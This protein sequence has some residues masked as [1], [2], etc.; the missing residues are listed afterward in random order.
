MTFVLDAGL[1]SRLV[2]PA[3]AQYR[4]VARWIDG[5]LARN[6]DVIALPEIADYEVRRKL[7]HLVRRGQASARSLARLDDL[8]RTLE[9]LPL[10]TA[11]VRRAAEL[12][13]GARLRGLP[14]ASSDSLDADAILA[15]QALAVGGTVVT[16]NPRHLGR[17]VAVR[18]WSDVETGTRQT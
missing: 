5:L 14:T 13:A 8:G 16:T 15:A 9:Y 2:H 12:W 6:R 11:T 17:Y 10:T 18:S 4:P 7:L 1:V 3:R